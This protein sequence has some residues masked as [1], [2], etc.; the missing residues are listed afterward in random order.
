MASTIIQSPM[1][2][3]RRLSTL[4]DPLLAFP[5]SQLARY[6]VR[7]TYRILPGQTTEAHITNSLIAERIPLAYQA[8]LTLFTLISAT[9]I[10][11]L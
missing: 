6:R 7:L 9:L 1:K 5:H 2:A 10:Y 4:T 3:A 11:W 8:K